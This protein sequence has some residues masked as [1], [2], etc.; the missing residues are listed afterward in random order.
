MAIGE[1]F[2]CDECNISYLH[3]KS[4]ASKKIIFFLPGAYNRTKG[5]T[6]YQRHSWAEDYFHKFDCVFVDDPT[7]NESNSLSI[8]WFQGN[9]GCNAFDALRK[10][11]HFLIKQSK[12]DESDVVFFGSSAGGFT[13]LRL[14]NYFTKSTVIA[15]N[16]QIYLDNYHK[17]FFYDMMSYSHSSVDIHNLSLDT[18]KKISFIPDFSPGCGPIY[19][20]QN[21]FDDHHMLHHVGVLMKSFQNNDSIS[22][23]FVSCF[24]EKINIRNRINILY[25][26]DHEKKHNPPG[27]G[28][29]KNLILSLI[30][31]T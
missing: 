5:I 17:K 22:T 13:C 28:D 9:D 25:Y 4:E 21:K 19:I 23:E 26:E 11:V 6:Q 8:G 29:T 7:I 14:S 12:I 10:L 2:A 18:I 31:F 1:I 24:G 15:I 20:I 3:V 27:K 30:D 16:P